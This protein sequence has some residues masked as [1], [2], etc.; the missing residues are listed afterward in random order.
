MASNANEHL[1]PDDASKP[2]TQAR[3]WRARAS[4]HW[5]QSR[6]GFAFVFFGVVALSLGFTA[7][8]LCRLLPGTPAER[9]ARAQRLIHWTYGFF[10]RSLSALG[11]TRMRFEGFERLRTSGPHLV[12][13]NHPT[14]I[15][16]GILISQLP[17]ADCIVSEAWA[18]SFFVGRIARAAGYVVSTS[19]AEAVADSAARL[20]AGRTVLWFP[21]GSRSSRGGLRPFQRGAAHVALRSGCDLEPVTIRCEPLT[22][23]KGEPWWDVPEQCVEYRI[24]VEE[25][26][27]VAS[28]GREALSDVL[29]ARRVTAALENRIREGLRRE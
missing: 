3:T 17:Q 23:V 14:L 16:F 19:G 12:V 7:F 8:P 4:R 20:A 11:L 24:R 10:V 2:R 5:R 13:A 9:D 27:C 18:K 28:V 15:D 21:E 26:V 25:P 1:L 29:A 6:T 22:L